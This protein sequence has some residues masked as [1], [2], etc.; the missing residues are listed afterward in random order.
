MKRNKLLTLFAAA[1]MLLGVQNANADVTY[2]A[3]N[4]S[5][6]THN[7]EN[8][9]ALFDGKQNT[10]WGNR[11]NGSTSWVV[12]KS[13]SPILPT[14]YKLRIAN[15]TSE[16]NGRNWKNWKIYGGNFLTDADATQ[17]ASGWVEIDNK[18]NQS[19]S[20]TPFTEQELSLTSPGSNHYFYYFKIEVSAL[21]KDGEYGQMDEFWFSS[22]TE[23]DFVYAVHSASNPNGGEGARRLF[24]GHGNTKWGRSTSP[25]N[26]SWVI[27]K[28]SK[29]INATSYTLTE[30]NDTPNSKGR[31]WKKWKIYGANF[32]SEMQFAADAVEWVLLDEK[33]VKDEE[34]PISGS[35][36]SYKET[37]F[38]MSESNT[39][40]YEYFKIVVEDLRTSGQYGQMGDFR[41]NTP[42]PQAESDTYAAKVALAKAVTF[43]PQT[44]GTSYPLYTEL[45]DLTS[46]TTLDTYLSNAAGNYTSL[47]GK[48]DEVYSLQKVMTAYLGGRDFFGITGSD[49][50][51]GDGHYDNLVDGNNNTKWG[52]NFPGSGEKVMWMIF[53]AKESIKPY[54]YKLLTA[55][56]AQSWSGRNWKDWTIKGGN[57]AT[58]DA[59]Q[60]NASGWTPIDTRTNIGQDL[61]PA[62]NGHLA[63]FGVNGTFNDAYDYFLVEV[64]NCY[65]NGSQI[66]MNELILGTEEEFNQTKTDYMADLNAYVVPNI[67]TDQQK[68][69][70]ADAKTAVQNATPENILE[71]YN[72][73]KAIQS[74]IFQS[75]KDGD[76]YQITSPSDLEFF[77]DLVNIGGEPNAKGKLTQD[78]NLAGFKLTQI[79]GAS[80]FTGEFDG[81]GHVISHLTDYNAAGWR[82][83][84]FGLT[85]GATIADI[86]F[87]DAEIYGR[88]NMS[89]A[90]GE[91][92]NTTIK[93]ILVRN[94]VLGTVDGG[95]RLGGI[96]GHMNGGTI[97]NCAVINST[98]KGQNYVGAIVGNAINGATVKNCY[99]NA[100][101][102]AQG[103]YAGGVAGAA[104]T[105]T[106]E[107]NLYTGS[108]R[109]DYDVAAGL[110]GLFN[111]QEN[112]DYTL[113]LQKN[114][115]A[116]PTVTAPSTR[117]LIN[118]PAFPDS[119]TTNPTY[120]GNYLLNSTV[121][122]DETKF[123]DHENDV[124][125]KQMSFREV[126]CKSF[127]ATT[128]GW[129]ME[130]DWKFVAAGQFPVL[131]YMEAAAPAPQTISVTDAGYATVVAEKEIDF[132]GVEGIT[133]Y[134]A[135]VVDNKYVHLE[136][137][138]IVPTGEAFVVK[139]PEGNYNIPVSLEEN[140]DATDNDLKAST[141]DVI[142]D[143]SQYILAN[144]S[145]GVGFY[146]AEANST[147]AAGKGYLE[148][149][150]A[151]VK[152][153]YG[154]E[155]NDA[156]GIEETL[157]NSPLKGENIFNLAG[158]RLNK[159]QKGIN[160]MDGKKVLK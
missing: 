78:I 104:Q 159:M 50:C 158:Q 61:L 106:I 126:T 58:M 93:N 67:A 62:K 127:Y 1:M 12:F 100:D 160:I 73:A 88:Y 101:V 117:T 6:W 53:R 154:F 151:G 155:F 48:L 40:S 69:D 34:F 39:G 122:S 110:V 133:A 52:G 11:L 134:I 141:T 115:V 51:W 85:N 28:T 57:F 47:K 87:E 107:K 9:K 41:F 146:K 33:N 13:S 74:E 35:N 92:T 38:T 120:S 70:Y 94:C 65:S 15:D 10:K 121:Y 75:L 46:G 26:P 102:Y 19:L 23:G 149:G 14:K 114:M 138:T 60:R 77:S 18:S 36:N 90:V 72:A 8:P 157:S 150:G 80:D 118:V 132:T 143:G 105:A 56:D 16:S 49:G 111:V 125:G 152:G 54:F 27:F 2:T 124:N 31:N 108:L 64:T 81:Q 25:D 4:G 7:S 68:Q 29:A 129:D 37:S 137:I 5:N 153:F 17:D 83:G 148:I 116:A 66:Q 136:P 55:W 113:V 145:E 103:S 43:D 130:N 147:I 32:Y 86:I 99:S 44:L 22:Y 128:L 45:Q 30:A 82:S 142:A 98:L 112:N 59:A 95:D 20:N 140:G 63:P 91:A 156:T 21:M 109:S 131:A 71:K 84:L 135:Q 96:A 119:Q 144:G 89:V 123:V 3:L 42:T 76:F 139:A 24:D 97:Q 79:G